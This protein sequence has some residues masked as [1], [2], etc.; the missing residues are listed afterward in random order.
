[1]F[2]H[3][4]TPRE[5]QA[6][7]GN[8]VRGRARG[9]RRGNAAVE[10]IVVMPVLVLFLLG[11]IEF[12]M[13]LTARQ[14]LLSA[15]AAGARVGARGGTTTEIETQVNNV[16]GYTATVTVNSIAASPPTTRDGVEVLVMVQTTNLVPNLLPQLID[17]T[18]QQ[19][20]GR[21]VMNLE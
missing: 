8:P 2:W 10:L 18:G 1:M 3:P 19:L 17:F 7:L 14:Q 16:L 13:L 11:T 6:G 5:T 12:S 4:R 9:S 21:A 15:A 20:T